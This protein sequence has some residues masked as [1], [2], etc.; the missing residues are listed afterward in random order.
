MTRRE[1]LAIVQSIKHFHHYLYGQKFKVRTD[2]GS[3]RWLLRFKNPEGQIARWLETLASYQF[4]IEHRAGCLHG[5]A[6]ALSRRPC[7]ESD[8]TYCIKVEM[9]YQPEQP[10]QKCSVV[11]RAQTTNTDNSAENRDAEHFNIDLGKYQAEDPDLRH[12]IKW[13]QDGTQPNWEDISHL[14]EA[15][16]F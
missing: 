14:S 10:V 5:N 4:D 16:K 1:L 3:L 7:A 15:C 2:H 13:V 11:T 8:C 12:V 6:D 9:K